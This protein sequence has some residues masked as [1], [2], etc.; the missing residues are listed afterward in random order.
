MNATSGVAARRGGVL[1]ASRK[2]AA[3]FAYGLLP[4]ALLTVMLAGSIHDHFA[5]DF[6]QFWQ[7]GRDVIHG[8][9]PYPPADGVPQGGDATRK[10][11]RTSIAFRTLRPPRC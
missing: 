9:S 4:A 5:F 8:H 6:H 10:G 2:V 7:G 11:F 3:A 1:F